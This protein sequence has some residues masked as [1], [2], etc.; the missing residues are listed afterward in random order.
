MTP[1]ANPAEGKLVEHTARLKIDGVRLDQYLVGMFGE[2]SRSVV[3][4]LIGGGGVRVNR[5]PAKAASRSS[6]FVV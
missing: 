4:R 6:S 5:K 2:Y 1:I 3:Q